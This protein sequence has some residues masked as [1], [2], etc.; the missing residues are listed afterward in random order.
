MT[1]IAGL[2][3]AYT[4]A[5][6][7]CPDICNLAARYG[8]LNVLKWAIKK[9]YQVND[10]VSKEA[11]NNKEILIWLIDN[12]YKISTL[13]LNNIAKKGDLDLLKYAHGKNTEINSLVAWGA[14]EFGHLH[15]LKWMI[16]DINVD[17]K[18]NEEYWTCSWAAHGGKLDVL[19]WLRDNNFRWNEMTTSQAAVGNHFE[20][21]K[22]VIDNGCPFD[23]LTF[24]NAAKHKGKSSIE[25][26]SW[27]RRIGCPWD[28]YTCSTAASSGNLEAL[29]WLRENGCPWSERTC[30][31]AALYGQLEVLKWAREHGCPWSTHTLSYA[32]SKGSIETLEYLMNNRCPIDSEACA[33]AA[34]RGHLDVLKWL[35]SKGCPWDSRTISFAAL[36]GHLEVV[37]YAMMN[38]CPCTMFVCEY[39]V[40]KSK[41]PDL[42]KWMIEHGCPCNGNF[43]N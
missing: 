30:D 24:A 27:L 40:N 41:Y 26:L 19:K 9:K 34:E 6:L 2:E 3:Y 32:A 37:K 35:R 13:A 20:V 22:Y 23:E 15:I 33:M 12:G 29:Q 11:S 16:Y 8:Q 25:T 42:S 31:L 36:D 43:H 28:E 1:N 21:L 7:C 39:S 4:H 18:E 38:G 14:A 5:R 10:F 17:F